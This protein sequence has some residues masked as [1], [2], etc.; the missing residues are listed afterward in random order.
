MTSPD[1]EARRKGI[2]DEQLRHPGKNPIELLDKIFFDIG[3]HLPESDPERRNLIRG[4][5]ELMEW[6]GQLPSIVLSEQRVRTAVGEQSDFD[7][8]FDELFLYDSHP[9]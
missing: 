9:F 2:A 4:S 5:V 8:V 3:S 6:V 7:K 1:M